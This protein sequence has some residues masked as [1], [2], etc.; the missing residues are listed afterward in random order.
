MACLV[1]LVSAQLISG[2]LEAPI[3]AVEFQPAATNL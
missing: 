3:A 2:W 1:L